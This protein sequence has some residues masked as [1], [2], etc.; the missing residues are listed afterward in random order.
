M[1]GQVSGVNENT[2]PNPLMLKE[3]SKHSENVKQANNTQYK[4]CTLDNF[5]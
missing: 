1:D 4:V 5:K 2:P 3:D